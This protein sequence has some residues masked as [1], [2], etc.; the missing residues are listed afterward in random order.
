[1]FTARS[2]ALSHFKVRDKQVIRLL[3]IDFYLS[4]YQLLYHYPIASDSIIDIGAL[5]IHLLTYLLMWLSYATFKW[6]KRGAKF[7][8]L[9]ARSDI[10]ITRRRIRVTAQC[11]PI[12]TPMTH[13]QETCTKKNFGG[14][15]IVSY[16]KFWWKFLRVL[17]QTCGQYSWAC[18]HWTL[19]LF[20]TWIFF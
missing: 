14:R 13:D 7:C 18:K 3:S 2:H 17:V 12:I 15:Y 11:A 9:A 20:H 6:W 16:A 8:E 4:L 19:S 10:S 5:Q 1:M